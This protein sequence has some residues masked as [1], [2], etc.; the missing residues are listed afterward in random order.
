MTNEIL[1]LIS[2]LVIYGGVVLFYRFFGKGGLLAF[3]VLATLLANIEVLLLVCRST[4]FNL[5]Y[6]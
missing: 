4:R 6:S 5:S 3:N 1:I 2:F